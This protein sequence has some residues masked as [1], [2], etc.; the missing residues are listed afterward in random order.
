MSESPYTSANCAV[1]RPDATPAMMV[2]WMT[3]APEWGFADDPIRA[4]R[5]ASGNAL[6]S[7]IRGRHAAA[8]FWTEVGVALVAAADNPYI[9]VGASLGALAEK[10]GVPVGGG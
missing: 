1:L 4:V 9:R 3:T 8:K 2:E 6:Q 7:A 10:Y 5:A